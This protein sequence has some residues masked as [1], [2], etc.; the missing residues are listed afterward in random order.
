MVSVAVEVISETNSKIWS[1]QFLLEG[2]FAH[3]F[4]PYRRCYHMKDVQW[5]LEL[6]NKQEQWEPNHGQHVH[7]KQV[8]TPEV[9]QLYIRYSHKYALD[10]ESGLCKHS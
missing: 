2:F 6:A 3:F 10:I 1:I 4:S 5:F 8:T 9:G 7:H